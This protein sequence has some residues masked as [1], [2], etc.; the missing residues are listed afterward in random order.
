MCIIYWEIEKSLKVSFALSPD[1]LSIQLAKVCSSYTL[2]APKQCVNLL[3]V[4]RIKSVSHRRFSNDSPC[5]QLDD[6][7]PYGKSL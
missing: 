1:N 7:F 4:S 2:K 3:N 5:N 6:W